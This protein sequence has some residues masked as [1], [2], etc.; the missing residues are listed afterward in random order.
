MFG[1]MACGLSI[2]IYKRVA[3]LQPTHEPHLPIVVD[4]IE[5]AHWGL[6]EAPTSV[7]GEAARLNALMVRYTSA[8]GAAR[9]A[10]MIALA[11]RSRSEALSRN[12]LYT[13]R[14]APERV[15]IY[16]EGRLR[17]AISKGGT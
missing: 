8:E 2:F 11:P 17:V 7:R 3:A 1:S 10:V 9:G 6:V 13:K 12:V 14:Q 15:A 16:M 4:L 5:G